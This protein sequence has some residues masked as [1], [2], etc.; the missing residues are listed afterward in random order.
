VG[1]DKL[2]RSHRWAIIASVN[3]VIIGTGCLGLREIDAQK[4][5]HLTQFSGQ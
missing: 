4:A 2:I 3:S 1:C 5:R